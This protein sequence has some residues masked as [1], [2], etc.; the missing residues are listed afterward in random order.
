MSSSTWSAGW[1]DGSS[2]AWDYGDGAGALDPPNL[3]RGTILMIRQPDR[4]AWVE[5][6]V[7]AKV[8]RAPWS[9]VVVVARSELFRVDFSNSDLEYIIEEEDGIPAR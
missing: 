5:M 1:E 3:E 8:P 4:P 6:V 2:G 9:F 7:L